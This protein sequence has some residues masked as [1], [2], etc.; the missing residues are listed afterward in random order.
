MK[1]EGIAEKTLFTVDKTYIAYATDDKDEYN[2]IKNLHKHVIF[3]DRDA[4]VETTAIP[5][6]AKI[7]EL[8]GNNKPYMDR[9]AEGEYEILIADDQC[10][11]E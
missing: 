3:V 9:E 10:S 2:M 7:S 11:C 5:G 4:A 8:I 6:T 1:H